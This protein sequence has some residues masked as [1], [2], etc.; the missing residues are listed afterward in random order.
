V[1]RPAEG[2][3]Y[4][5]RAIA[6]LK[7][8][9]DPNDPV[10]SNAM[11]NKGEALFALGQYG[12]ALAS[13][14]QALANL[15]QQAGAPGPTLAGGLSGVGKTKLALGDPRDAVAPLERA[16]EIYDRFEGAGTTGADTRF[17]FARALWDGGGERRRAVRLAESA[18]EAYAKLDQQKRVTTIAE[19]LAAHRL[20]AR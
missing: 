6:I 12:R 10:L 2:I 14:Q 1:G 4:A 7:K 20:A 11:V 17:A 13:F 9:A 5:D 19:W 18:R 16:N 15:T 3:P 8:T